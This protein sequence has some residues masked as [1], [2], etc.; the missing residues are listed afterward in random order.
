MGPHVEKLRAIVLRRI[1]Y[2]ESDLV[3]HVLSPS[4]GKV[5]CLAKGALKSKRRFGGGVLEPTHFIEMELRPSPRAD[6]LATLEEA[7]MIESFEGLRSSYERL[8]VALAL[9][10]MVDRVAQPGDAGSQH[11]FDLLGNGLRALQTA[12]SPEILR[13]QFS[14]KLLYHQG[15][16]ETEPWMAPFLKTP[17]KIPEGA[18][19]PSPTPGQQRW[20][21]EQIE[22]YLKTAERF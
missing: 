5:S 21:H 13:A 4:G 6:G 22:V 17:L 14:L 12:T 2:G 8:E 9:I 1:K 18:G 10:D 19:V 15:V 16:L 11:L 7:H 20:I 3:L